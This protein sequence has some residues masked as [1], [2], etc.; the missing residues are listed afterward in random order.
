MKALA[1]DSS[2]SRARSDADYSTS[3]GLSATWGSSGLLDEMENYDPTYGLRPDEVRMSVH[4]SGYS[5][6]AKL[7]NQINGG[8]RDLTIEDEVNKASQQVVVVPEEL[9]PIHD[10]GEN[11][12]FEEVEAEQDTLHHL[13]L[14]EDDVPDHPASDEDE[15][16]QGDAE[17][18]EDFPL[19]S[20]PPLGAATSSGAIDDEASVFGSP[21]SVKFSSK[22]TRSQMYGGSRTSSVVPSASRIG[23]SK[24]NKIEYETIPAVGGGI[25]TRPRIYHSASRVQAPVMEEDDVVQGED[26]TSGSLAA[27]STIRGPSSSRTQTVRLGSSQHQA[28]DLSESDGEQERIYTTAVGDGS[29]D[30]LE[31]EPMNTGTSTYRTQLYRQQSGRIYRA[32]Y[33]R[34]SSKG[35]SIFASNDSSNQRLGAIASGSADYSGWSTSRSSTAPTSTHPSTKPPS[36]VHSRRSNL[37]SPSNHVKTERAKARDSPGQASSPFKKAALANSHSMTIG[38]SHNFMDLVNSNHTLSPFTRTLDTKGFA[39]RSHPVTPSTGSGGETS[40]SVGGIASRPLSATS[41][42]SKQWRDPGSYFDNHRVTSSQTGGVR[43][44][45]FRLGAKSPSRDAENAAVALPGIEKRPDSTPIQHSS[46]SSNKAPRAHSAASIGLASQAK[47]ASR[48]ANSSD[49]G[50]GSSDPRRRSGHAH[51]ERVITMGAIRE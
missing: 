18:E 19:Y 13:D 7:A 11:L 33:G 9:T 30:T 36:P 47:P 3:F 2:N 4:Q 8:L 50:Y 45:T 46:S 10:E 49:S 29:L 43:R 5:G 23:P 42:S 35:S 40:S 22:G 26:I 39:V 20:L 17:G 31:P 15:G 41:S 12:S 44:R 27:S 14:S 25:I 34:H 6:L 32:G 1:T 24:T 28:S 48:R 38:A 21:S 37:S 51:S 16:L